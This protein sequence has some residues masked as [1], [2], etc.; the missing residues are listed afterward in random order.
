MTRREST[1]VIHPGAL[2]DVLQAVPALRALRSRSVLT[3]A[4]Q[5]RFGALLR[6]LRVVDAAVSF[7]SLG[8]S[9]LFTREPLPAALGERLIVFDRVISWFGAREATYRERLAAAARRVMIAP[10]VP[11]DESPVPVWQHL[12]AT[13]GSP[14][15]ADLSPLAVPCAWRDEAHGALDRIGVATGRALLV[16]HPGAG[17]AWKRWPT[18]DLVDAIDRVQRETDAQ[19]LIHQGPADRDAA[20]ELARAL[21]SPVPR[22]V[23]PVLPLLAG[24]LTRASAYLGSDSGVSHLAAAV[25]AP[26]TILFPDAT[27]ERWRPWSPTARIIA[28]ASAPP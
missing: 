24:V 16:I 23:E 11:G 12:L 20:D 1:L 3:F 4:G 17:G 6:D 27:R 22:L 15:V 26:A 8:L 21:A 9:A 13:I 25:G 18:R 2:G 28:P 5:S 19:A 10:P 7:D 14:S